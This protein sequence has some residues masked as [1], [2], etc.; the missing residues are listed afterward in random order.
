M[1]LALG[2]MVVTGNS[3]IPD[4]LVTSIT[5]T[6]QDVQASVSEVLSVTA[7]V[8]LAIMGLV[9]AVTVGM[10]LFKSMTKTAARG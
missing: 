6:A 9:L 7:P 10:R 2:T 3:L 8:A 5:T 1:P 4:D